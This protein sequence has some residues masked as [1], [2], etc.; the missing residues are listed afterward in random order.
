MS[1]AHD[2]QDDDELI[3]ES[4]IQAE[5]LVDNDIASSRSLTDLLEYR[6]TF[7][8]TE[9]Y[10]CVMC[11]HQ[12][13]T[14]DEVQ[15]HIQQIHFNAK[16]ADGR[17]AV[18]SRIGPM[19]SC[20]KCSHTESS[21]DG[22]KRHKLVLHL[23]FIRMCELCPYV[24]YATSDLRWHMRNKHK[25]YFP[26]TI[27][28]KSL[29]TCDTEL[30]LKQHI[31]KSKILGARCK[32]R[33]T[34]N[35]KNISSSRHSSKLLVCPHCRLKC[36][37]SDELINHVVSVHRGRKNNY[38]NSK[39]TLSNCNENL[40]TSAVCRTPIDEPPALVA[41]VYKC[42]FCAEVSADLDSLA[43]HMECSHEEEA[44][45]PCN[46]CSH[47]AVSSQHLSDHVSSA[48]RYRCKVCRFS[49]S[50]EDIVVTHMR[51]LHVNSLY[52]CDLCSFM[53]Q[54]STAL[55]RHKKTKH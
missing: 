48:H 47:V 16:L 32:S 10:K 55:K 8:N 12:S 5:V 46:L 49:S 18:D 29:K 24:A 34:N 51:T 22:L 7:T 23:G 26:S 36:L 21:W 3:G 35:T 41:A 33:Q 50:E 13:E 44:C 27:S 43:V 14:G 53:C 2:N 25:Q 9:S 38:D 4:E 42:D 1:L 31:Y 11:P 54:Q 40:F 19:Y 52:F 45:V 6:K 28:Q 37:T 30:Q 15:K 39:T 17:P 20:D